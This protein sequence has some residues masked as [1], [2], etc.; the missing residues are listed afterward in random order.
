MVDCGLREG[1]ERQMKHSRHVPGPCGRIALSNCVA[2]HF[3]RETAHH[4][5][6][7]TATEAVDPR[8]ACRGMS[9]LLALKF[10]SVWSFG[11]TAV[12]LSIKASKFG[13]QAASMQTCGP[14]GMCIVD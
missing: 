2:L 8:V 3:T 1:E 13:I 12:M 9:S 14:C 5:I 4:P 11:L 6:E 7:L 10:S